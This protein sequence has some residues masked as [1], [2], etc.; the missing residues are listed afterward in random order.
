MPAQSLMVR[1]HFTYFG[2]DVAQRGCNLWQ[3]RLQPHQIPTSI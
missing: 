3:N 1:L 2:S